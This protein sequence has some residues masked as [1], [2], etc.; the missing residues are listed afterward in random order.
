L[1]DNSTRCLVACA[2]LEI[3]LS[4]RCC[5]IGRKTMREGELLSVDGHSGICAD[6][7]KVVAEHPHRK[8]ARIQN[9][10]TPG[11]P[12]SASKPVPRAGQAGTS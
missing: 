6:N 12:D 7:P 2:D 3:H 1:R 4:Q 5:R 10:R 11:I 8:L 9:W